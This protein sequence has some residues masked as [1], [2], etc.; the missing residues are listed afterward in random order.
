MFKQQNG[1]LGMRFIQKAF[2]CDSTREDTCY[3]FM[4]ML[5]AMGQYSKAINVFIRHKN[6]MI[7]K[8]GVENSKRVTL[9][10]EEI[11][12]ELS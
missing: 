5:K 9:L 4:K 10:Y 11:L 2:L 7:D 1:Q 8:Y 6:G 12:K 3:L